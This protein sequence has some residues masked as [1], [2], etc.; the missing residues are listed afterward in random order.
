MN[1]TCNNDGIQYFWKEYFIEIKK[2]NT[3]HTHTKYTN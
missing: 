1:V 2:D 3:H